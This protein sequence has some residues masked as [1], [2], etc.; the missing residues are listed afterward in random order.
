MLSPATLPFAAHAAHGH[1]E[2][3]PL[4]PRW[5]QCD[6]AA[7]G[8]CDERR[9]ALLVLAGVQHRSWQ[10]WKRAWWARECQWPQ[11]YAELLRRLLDRHARCAPQRCSKK[12]FCCSRCTGGHQHSSDLVAVTSLAGAH[13]QPRFCFVGL[14]PCPAAGVD[15]AGHRVLCARIVPHVLRVQCTSTLRSGCADV[16]DF[17]ATLKAHSSLHT[18]YTHAVTH[19]CA[20]V[21]Q[22]L[23]LCTCPMPAPTSDKR[24]LRKYEY[25]YAIRCL[26]CMQI[27]LGGTCPM[28]AI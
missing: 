14:E 22:Q 11:L 20:V 3:V 27:H 1:V 26:L 24:S 25:E 15:L 19:L 4:E 10:L 16:T 28:P 6:V 13:E 2:G 23:C 12:V 18:L 17:Y 8:S 9:P 21:G 7:C 5:I